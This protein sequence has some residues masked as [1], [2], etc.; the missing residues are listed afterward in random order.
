MLSEFH[1]SLTDDAGHRSDNFGVREI[2][3]RLFQ[4]R[5]CG[6][7]SCFPDFYIRAAGC[8]GTRRIRLSLLSL[9]LRLGQLREGLI[10]FLA[11]SFRTGLRGIDGGGLSFSVSD[12]RIVLLVGN[13]FF[14][15]RKL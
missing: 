10:D 15:T 14:N 13:F 6:D 5:L 1:R 2:Q 8:Q 11:R 9:A 3:L 4:L 12:D 7:D